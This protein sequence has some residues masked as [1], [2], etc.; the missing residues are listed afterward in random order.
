MM[1]AYIMLA[2]FSVVFAAYGLF[3]HFY[4]NRKISKNIAKRDVIS[5]SKA[6]H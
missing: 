5:V 3:E 4:I 2:L 1:A 6:H